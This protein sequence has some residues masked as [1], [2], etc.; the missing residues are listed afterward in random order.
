MG[1][2]GKM[3]KEGKARVEYYS[4]RDLWNRTQLELAA[5]SY[6]STFSPPI[7]T[8]WYWEIKL[9]LGLPCRGR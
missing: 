6:P 1:A 4:T 5:L 8:S 7:A 3:E 9:F 2:D